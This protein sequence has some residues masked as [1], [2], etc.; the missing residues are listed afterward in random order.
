MSE[1]YANGQATK[2]EL[3][4][5]GKQ[6]TVAARQ[7]QEELE[8]ARRN[9]NRGFPLG[10]LWEGLRADEAAAACT[11][12]DQVAGAK[13]VAESA[14]V[15]H[16]KGTRRG[17]IDMLRDIFS[18]PF[19]PTPSI[20]PE[21]LAGNYQTVLKMT[22]AIYDERAF[23]CLPILADALEDAGCEDATILN[24]CRQADDHVR[25]CWVVDLLLGQ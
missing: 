2:E 23:D 8:R 13:R 22:H 10:L 12:A 20:A 19:H 3:S 15:Y 6:A 18:N 9:G 16:N 5:A 24:H 25:G 21:I 17:I 7:R 11:W 14:F 4:A 1:R